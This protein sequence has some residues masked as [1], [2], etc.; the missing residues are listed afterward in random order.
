MQNNNELFDFLKIDEDSAQ[1]KNINA[2]DS[3]LAG[4]FAAAGPSQKI[5]DNIMAAAEKKNT[6]LAQR[7]FGRFAYRKILAAA[8][9]VFIL[10]LIPGIML[11][12]TQNAADETQTYAYAVSSVGGDIENLDTGLDDVLTELDYMEE[13]I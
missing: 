2:V 9:A 13:N 4:Q 5:L 1:A 6:P 7:I 10:A 12:R 11:K 8:A 3:A